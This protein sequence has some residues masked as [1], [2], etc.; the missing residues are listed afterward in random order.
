MAAS[1]R[2]TRRFN[3]LAYTAGM[4]HELRAT[5]QTVHLGGFSRHLPP[6]LT[7]EPGDTVRVETFTGMKVYDRS[8]A[9][10]RHPSLDRIVRELPGSRVLGDGPHLLTGPIAVRGTRPGDL[11]EV[12][13]QRIELS[14][15]VGFNA[16]LSGGWG[17]LPERFGEDRLWFIDLDR[18]AM[19]AEVPPGSGTRVPLRPFFGELAVA[20][21]E[22]QPSS[23]PPGRFGGNLDNR[24]LVEGARVFLPVQVEGAL[25]SIG[26]GHAAQG[27]GE[28]N[29]NA[30]EASMRGTIRL[31]VRRE[32]TS[33]WPFAITPTHLVAMGFAPTLDEA[34]RAA[35][36]QMVDLLGG[37]AGM[38]GEAA[39]ALASVAASFRVTQ[40]VNTPMRGV[41]GLLPLD[42]LP[43][44]LRL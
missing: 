21:A 35:V 43:G 31:D 9:G 13:L 22:G 1:Y 6:T 30:I 4:E 36:G 7:V 16:T 44:P 26:D 28:V 39:Y 18:Q 37:L 20:P 24:E 14:L 17:V 8:P 19:V 42:T 3:R 38:D 15:P 41:H 23:V 40:A 32:L 2:P 34:L 12:Q 25:F 10:F 27:D 29:V 33:D 5:P 11:L